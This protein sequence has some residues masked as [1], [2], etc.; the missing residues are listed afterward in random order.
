M[1]RASDLNIRRNSVRKITAGC[2]SHGAP[3]DKMVQPRCFCVEASQNMDALLRIALHALV[4]NEISRMNVQGGFYPAGVERGALVRRRVRRARGWRRPDRGGA[5]GAGVG[6]A[7]GR[8]GEGPSRR[9]GAA[10]ADPGGRPPHRQPGT[11]PPR[12]AALNPRAKAPPP[13]LW[14]VLTRPRIRPGFMRRVLLATRQ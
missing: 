7:A 12:A 11:L 13:L 9:A 10:A 5:A 4:S 8:G 2:P 6:G 1:H 14:I 3:V